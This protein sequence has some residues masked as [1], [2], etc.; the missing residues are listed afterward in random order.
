MQQFYHL[1][2]LITNIFNKGAI[3]LHYVWYTVFIKG[4]FIWDYSRIGILE[5]DGICVLLG[6][7]PFSE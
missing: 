5:M 7:I 1:G 4:A 6:A 3:I 2:I